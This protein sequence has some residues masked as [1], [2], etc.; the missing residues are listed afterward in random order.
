WDNSVHLRNIRTDKL[1]HL[2][3][4]RGPALTVAFSPDDKWLASGSWDNTV[5]LWD[6]KT[7]RELDVLSVHNAP[8]TSVAFY[9][10][11]RLLASG[12]R[13]KTIRLRDLSYLNLSDSTAA[14]ALADSARDTSA[15]LHDLIYY[16]TSQSFDSLDA[17]NLS[18]ET[19]FQAY[20]HYLS[21][22]LDQNLDLASEPSK[23]YLLSADSTAIP[24]KQHPFT[25]LRKPRPQNTGPIEWILSRLP[26]KVFTKRRQP[27]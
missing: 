14:L 4:H 20:A 21:Y 27:K 6:T 5:R 8:V 2:N 23:F 15:R 7:S 22:R 9:S 19:V 18:F 3:G 1:I 17:L 12:S 13:D 16:F 10:N 25:F 26:E 24:F 11:G